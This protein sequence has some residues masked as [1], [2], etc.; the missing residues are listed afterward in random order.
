MQVYDSLGLQQPIITV[1]I[2]D[3]RVTITILF[4]GD[5]YNSLIPKFHKETDLIGNKELSDIDCDEIVYTHIKIERDYVYFNEY[6]IR[7][8]DE[9]MKFILEYLIDSKFLEAI[10][11]LRRKKLL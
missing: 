8:T 11:K 6:P 9:T 5:H 7:Y 3:G 2:A 10:E 4:S 1:S